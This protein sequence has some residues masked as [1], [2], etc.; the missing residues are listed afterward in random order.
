MTAILDH[1]ATGTP[2]LSDGRELFGG[3]PGGTWATAATP[4]GT[5]RDLA[6]GPKTEPLTPAGGPG[7]A[8]PDRFPAARGAGPH[9]LNFPVTGIPDAPVQI[10]ACGI[11]PAG[12]SP[13]SPA[14][15]EA[16]PRPRDAHGTVIQVA[17]QA[18]PPP[19]APPRGATRAGAAVPPGLTGHRIGDLDGAARPFRYVLAAPAAGGSSWSARTACRWGRAAPHP[20]CPR[21]RRVQRPGPPARGAVGRAPRP[22]CGTGRRAPA[23]DSARP[24]RVSR[25]EAGNDVT[26]RPADSSGG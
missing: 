1:L 2:A 18:G 9:H 11:A 5:G 13:A 25:T 7:A 20:V 23:A 14:G 24:A 22:N 10:K 26:C 17:Q 15:G 4:P 12:V 3:A 16:F 6:A 21:G 19:S 8:F